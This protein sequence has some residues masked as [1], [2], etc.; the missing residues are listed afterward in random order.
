MTDTTAI[1]VLYITPDELDNTVHCDTYG[2]AFLTAKA[3]VTRNPGSVAEVF[4]R[5]DAMHGRNADGESS[6]ADYNRVPGDSW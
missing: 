6:E 1:A 5:T 2:E 3:Y 4:C